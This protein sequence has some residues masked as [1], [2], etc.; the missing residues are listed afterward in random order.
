M[1]QKL[2]TWT[3]VVSIPISTAIGAGAI[4]YLNEVYQTSQRTTY[5]MEEEIEIFDRIIEMADKNQIEPEV[6]KKSFISQKESRIATLKVME[7]VT[8]M[9]N[10]A[11]ASLL[12]V[13]ILQIILIRALLKNRDE[14]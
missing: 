6:I 7:G 4:I 8:D 14:K 11:I 10:N 12:F 2:L 13:L 9:R 1:N 5:T 3:L